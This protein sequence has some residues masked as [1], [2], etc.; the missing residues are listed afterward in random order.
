MN[1]TQEKFTYEDVEN[2]LMKP[3][4]WWA[5]VAILPFVRPISRY[6]ANRTKITPNQITLQ[7]S[8]SFTQSF[9]LSWVQ[10]F[11]NSLISLTV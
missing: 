1:E 2:A 10:C 6:I 8:S 3:K 4:S 5:I 9:S 7:S 11:L